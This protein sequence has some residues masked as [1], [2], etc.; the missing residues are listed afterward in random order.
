MGEVGG[1]KVKWEGLGETNKFWFWSS[2]NGGW[3]MKHLYWQN[4]AD[5]S[6]TEK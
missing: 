3:S 6:R 1:R 4:L 2:E 5:S